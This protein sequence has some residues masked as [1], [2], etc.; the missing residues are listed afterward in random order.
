MAVMMPMG[1]SVYETQEGEVFIAGMNLEQ[2]SMMFGGAVK[3]VLLAILGA[4]HHV[5]LRACAQLDSP[6]FL[7]S[8][9]RDVV[10]PDCP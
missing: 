7:R 2:M 3:E 10:R 5:D 8:I 4:L 6:V 9:S 1:V